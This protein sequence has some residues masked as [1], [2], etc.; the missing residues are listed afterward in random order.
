[1]RD[2]AESRRN[3]PA[4]KAGCKPIEDVCV[5][6]DEPLRC[7]HGCSE[8]RAHNCFKPP[9]TPALEYSR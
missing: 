4:N 6:H 9:R 2:E 3:K 8:A 1:M 5:M 7:P